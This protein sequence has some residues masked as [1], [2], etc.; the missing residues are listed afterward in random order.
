MGVWPPCCMCWG[1]SVAPFGLLGC[2]LSLGHG[3]GQGGP[4]WGLLDCPAGPVV[5]VR[6]SMG[7]AC[8]YTGLEL[9][10]GW[11]CCFGSGAAWWRPR[12][13]SGMYF[14]ALLAW[15]WLWSGA[16]LAVPL[17]FGGG[18]ACWSCALICVAYFGCT[19]LAGLLLCL[20]WGRTFGHLGASGWLLSVGGRWL[21]WVA[22]W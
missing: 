22:D 9:A 14:V 12:C 16:L 11:A 15:L 18:W 8:T 17:G 13:W 5:L 19:G 3:S 7:G 4:S 6:L 1:L 2:C 20:E 21:L 10:F